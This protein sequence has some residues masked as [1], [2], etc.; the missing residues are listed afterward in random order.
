MIL[1]IWICS[2]KSTNPLVLNWYYENIVSERNTIR[3]IHSDTINIDGWQAFDWHILKFSCLISGFYRVLNLKEVV[4][5]CQ[6][7]CMVWFFIVRLWWSANKANHSASKWF[8]MVKKQVLRYLLEFLP[9]CIQSNLRIT[10]SSTDYL[11]NQL[12]RK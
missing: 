9:I 7:N 12:D 11:H 1:W 10:N 8:I 4:Y 2:Y 3:G 5:E 6:R